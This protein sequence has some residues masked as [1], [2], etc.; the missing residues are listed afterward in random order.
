MFKKLCE[1]LLF[2]LRHISTKK[3]YQ[4]FLSSLLF[5]HLF[6]LSSAFAQQNFTDSFQRFSVIIAKYWSL[7]PIPGDT[8]GMRFRT[9]DD[10]PA[11]FQIHVFSLGLDNPVYF[12]E[13]IHHRNT[14]E[15]GYQL[16]TQKKLP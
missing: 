11:F 4:G 14:I 13:K 5:L 7:S 3:N 9:D 12:I 6:F 1:N 8:A 16:N 15:F 10:P 2:F